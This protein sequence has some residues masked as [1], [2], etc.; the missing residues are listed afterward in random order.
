MKI[1]FAL[2][3]VLVVLPVSGA[4]AQQNYPTKAVEIVVPF[5]AGGGTDLISRL[6][7]DYMG[8]KWGKPM[9]VVCRTT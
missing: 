9:L 5:A 4:L 1:V 2:I 8:K 6:V 3:A 7:A